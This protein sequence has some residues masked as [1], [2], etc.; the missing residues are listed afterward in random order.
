MLRQLEELSPVVDEFDV[1][2]LISQVRSELEGQIP[3]GVHLAV[4][5]PP[6]GKRLVVCNAHVLRVVLLE[7][8]RNSAKALS[9]SGGHIRLVLRS[10]RR[11]IA[12][13]V[14]DNGPGIPSIVLDYLARSDLARTSGIGLG[15]PLCTQLMRRFGGDLRIAHTSAEGTTIVVNIPRVRRASRQ[16]A[17]EH[18]NLGDTDA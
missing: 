5:R 7:L 1:T 4:G 14:T 13:V 10:E 15:L 8:I 12:I 2:L 17:P 9:S 18:P 6:R 16:L 3:E 11:N